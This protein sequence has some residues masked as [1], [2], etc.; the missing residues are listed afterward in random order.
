MAAYISNPEHVSGCIGVSAYFG[1]III[2]IVLYVV[3]WILFLMLEL[4][5]HV[6]HYTWGSRALQWPVQFMLTM[7]V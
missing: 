1:D 3:A 5:Q 2:C 7:L 6:N 4:L